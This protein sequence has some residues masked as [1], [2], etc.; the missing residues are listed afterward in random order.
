M[1]FLPY[2][3]GQIS[4]VAQVAPDLSMEIRPSNLSTTFMPNQNRGLF[5]VQPIPKGTIIFPQFGNIPAPFNDALIDLTELIV[6]ESSTAFYNVFT[7][8]IIEIADLLTRRN[9]AGYAQFIFDLEKTETLDPYTQKIIIMAKTLRKFFVKNYLLSNSN[10]DLVRYEKEQTG[11][12]KIS[13][14]LYEC[15]T[16]TTSPICPS[17]YKN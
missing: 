9:V 12:E 5:A 7:T 17:P 4:D 10:V 14:E 11:S 2:M 6:A 15:F 16:K 13:K 8:W 1:P 3:I